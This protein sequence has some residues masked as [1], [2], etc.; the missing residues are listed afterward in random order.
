MISQGRMCFIRLFLAVVATLLF[1]YSIRGTI[2]PADTTFWS[3]FNSHGAKYTSRSNGKFNGILQDR[4]TSRITS[5]CRTQHDSVLVVPCDSRSRVDLIHNNGWHHR[6]G[7]GEIAVGPLRRSISSDYIL[8][9]SRHSRRC[10]LLLCP[11]LGKP[12]VCCR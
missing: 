5:I 4:S 10:I 8:T 9:W 6:P 2:L 1:V 11:E 7:C 12:W 3:G